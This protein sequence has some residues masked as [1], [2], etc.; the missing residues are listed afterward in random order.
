MLAYGIWGGL[1]RLA[2]VPSGKDLA[3]LVG[4]KRDVSGISFSPD[5]K[6][7][8]TVADDGTVRLWH[9]ATRRELM[10]FPTPMKDPRTAAQVR[11]SPDG[12]TL[13][14]ALPD[15]E[16]TATHVWHAPSLDEIALAE[17][18]FDTLPRPKSPISWHLRAKALAKCGRLEE[19]LNAFGE[20]I[21]DSAGRPELEPLRTSAFQHRSQLLRRLGRPTEAGVDHCAAL[22]LPARDPQ[23]PAQCLDLSGFFNRPLDSESFSIPPTPFL[24]SLPTGIQALADTSRLRYDL[25]GVV[26]LRNEIRDSDDPSSAEGIVVQQ[27]CRK[28]HFLHSAHFCE[29]EDTA[30]GAYVLHYADG[31]QEEVPIRYGQHVR[32]WV[33]SVDQDEL[34]DATVAWTGTHPIKGTIRVFEQ[35]WENPH[36]EV[37]IE[38][39]DFMS[40]LRHSAPF[41]IAI[42]AE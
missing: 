2:A 16:E 40:T 24:D 7:L 12:G 37:E 3:T 17:K 22:N 8:A 26:Q 38:T 32:D 27:K 10:R 15:P 1:V 4:H 5:G 41:L 42:T 28:L 29:T 18:R 39:L 25:R 30:V 35:S 36:P 6:T 14:A 11:F 21:Q 33:L 34:R 20:V 13:V 31:R 9:I 23:A 19:A